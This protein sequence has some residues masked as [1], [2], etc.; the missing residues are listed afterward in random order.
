M[1]RETRP[2]EG[3]RS[4]ELTTALHAG[5]LD[6]INEKGLAITRNY[7]FV[8]DA[9]CPAAL[10]SMLIADALAGCGSVQEAVDFIGRQ[11]R[12]GAAI[13]TLADGS[14]DIAILE[15]LELSNTRAA[16]R[17]P[18]RGKDWLLA[19]NVCA[20]PEILPIQVPENY[21]YSDRAPRA[22]RGRRVLAWHTVRARRMQ[23][24]IEAKRIFGAAEL[25]AILAG[26]GPDGL[27]SG[28]TPC[29]HTDDWSTSATL[30]WF[31]ASRSL[32]VSN[33]SACCADYAEFAL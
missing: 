18:A 33:G 11:P 5:A 10:I 9:Q 17:R 13:L 23:Q 24:L 29:V 2:R 19:T 7:A 4:L 25:T 28:E 8:T 27:A 1:L 21:V 16:V 14:G 32:R 20:C 26:H 3:I 6:G 31:P 15:L 30:Q 22:L 12:W